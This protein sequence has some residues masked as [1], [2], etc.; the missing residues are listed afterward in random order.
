MTHETSKAKIYVV[1]RV[2]HSIREYCSLPKIP[3]ATSF[4]LETAIGI[5]R[6]E[7]KKE[8]D[9][10]VQTLREEERAINA[11][12]EDEYTQDLL[13]TLEA[14]LNEFTDDGGKID[15]IMWTVEECT[16]E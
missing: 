1:V 16:V 10:M 4:S 13:K 2:P 11:E 6:R 3:I 12:E 5:M 7:M 8:Y 9:E 15:D 14:E